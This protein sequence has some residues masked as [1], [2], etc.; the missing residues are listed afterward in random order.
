MP[1][2]ETNNNTL[3]LPWIESVS[4]LASWWLLRH[5]IVLADVSLEFFSNFFLQLFCLWP[6]YCVELFSSYLIVKLMLLC[7]TVKV[8]FITDAV[9]L[10]FAMHL[11]CRDFSCLYF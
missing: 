5:F 2:N 10:D 4:L 1:Q 8:L 9:L 11:M 7:Y 6:K 3:K